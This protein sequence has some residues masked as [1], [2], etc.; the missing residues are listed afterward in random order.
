MD[1]KRTLRRPIASRRRPIADPE[2][3]SSLIAMAS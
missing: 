2:A 1:W 3:V